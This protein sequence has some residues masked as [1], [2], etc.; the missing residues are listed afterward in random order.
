MRI[1]VLRIVA[2]YIIAVVIATGALNYVTPALYI[3]PEDADPIGWTLLNPL[4]LVAVALMLIL[5]VIRKVRYDRARHEEG[6]TESV[7]QHLDVNATFYGAVALAVLY[8]VSVAH[9]L[10]TPNE[11][12]LAIWFY[13][14]ALLVAV[15]IAI[16]FRIL[17]ASGLSIL[18]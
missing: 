13:V 18:Y 17:R 6:A 4:I 3:A 8:P 2:V 12:V 1:V 16:G 9:Q 15:G 14:D 5:S 10:A 11:P 7:I